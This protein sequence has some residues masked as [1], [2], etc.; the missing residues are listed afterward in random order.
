MS[1]HTDRKVKKAAKD[2]RRQV[3]KIESK[4]LT[5]KDEIMSLGDHSNTKIVVTHY[6]PEAKAAIKERY[7]RILD[8]GTLKER[9][10]DTSNNPTF[11]K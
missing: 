2:A 9:V 6:T 10:S 11:Y 3:F 7:N 8:I 1:Y 4:P 5:E